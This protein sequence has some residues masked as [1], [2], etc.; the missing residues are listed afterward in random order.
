[1]RNSKQ[2]KLTKQE[3]LVELGR[4][5]RE[6]A[7]LKIV[8]KLNDGLFKMQEHRLEFFQM[9]TGLTAQEEASLVPVAHFLSRL[10]GCL[11]LE[12][13]KEE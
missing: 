13:R 10:A 11:L 8:H 7:H 4:L 3:L 1:M 2:T 9:M 5:Q 6:N 12:E